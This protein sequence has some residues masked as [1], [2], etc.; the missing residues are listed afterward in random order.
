MKSGTILAILNA[1]LAVANIGAYLFGEAHHP[2]NLF[3]GMLNVTALAI[4]AFTY[5][6]YKL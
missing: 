6:R 3:A 2:L 5:W 1:V 4:T